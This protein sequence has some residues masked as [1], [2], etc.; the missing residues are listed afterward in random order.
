MAPRRNLLTYLATA[1]L[2]RAA[3]EATGPALLLVSIAALGSGATASYLVASLTGAAAIGG[4]IVE[5]LIDA[6]TAPEC[7]LLV[8]GFA[9]GGFAK[10]PTDKM[11]FRQLTAIGLI[12]G[13]A[14]RADPSKGGIKALLTWYTQKRIRPLVSEI[15][16][17]AE[18]GKAMQQLTT[19]A[20]KGK[21]IL[22]M[23]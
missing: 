3:T 12:Y 18:A 20:A 2:A 6:S 10:V 5:K 23:G 13:E 17:L 16:P 1:T 9:S 19:R 7:R 14:L 22:S 8:I 4:P 15:Y 11:L 21:V